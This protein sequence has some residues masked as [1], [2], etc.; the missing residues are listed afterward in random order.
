MRQKGSNHEPRAGGNPA[1]NGRVCSRAGCGVV[2]GLVTQARFGGLFCALRFAGQNVIVLL[3]ERAAS[4]CARHSACERVG[5]LR[6]RH[7]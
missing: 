6:Q 2:D 3:G 1:N 7:Q 4:G 5:G